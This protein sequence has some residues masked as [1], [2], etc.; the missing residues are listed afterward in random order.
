MVTI[1]NKKV[2]F[3]TTIILSPQQDAVIHS[4][5][6]KGCQ[7][8]IRMSAYSVM[9]QRPEELVT[10]AIGNEF[11]VEYPFV[12]D[13]QTFLASHNMTFAGGEMTMLTAAQGVSGGVVLN[14][15][16]QEA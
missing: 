14:V 1:G 13:Q 2:L 8:R 5:E 6:L 11:M 15:I 7:V 10:T 9:P 4:P 16:L 3:Q 12:H